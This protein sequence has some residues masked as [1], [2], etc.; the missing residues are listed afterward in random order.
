VPLGNTVVAE[1]K[2]VVVALGLAIKPGSS[3][4]ELM[5]LILGTIHQSFT[6]SI[7]FSCTEPVLAEAYCG[8]SGSTTIRSTAASRSSARAVSMLGF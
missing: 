7:T 2:V 5:K 4:N 1:Y 8:N 3:A 6:M